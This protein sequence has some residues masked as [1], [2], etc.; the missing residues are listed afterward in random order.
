VRIAIIAPLVTTIREP[1]L[2]GSQSFVADLA[3]GL[4]VRRHE[5]HVYAATGSEIP[6]ATVIDTG[7]DSAALRDSLYRAAS[8]RESVGRPVE[9]AFARVYA[10]VRRLSYDLVHN[11]AFDAPAIT[12]AAVLEVPVVHTLHLP[13]ER[14]VASALQAARH[15]GR[16]P[17]VAAVS[18]SQADAWRA[19]TPVDA[20]LPNGVPTARVPWSASVGSGAVFAGRFS[21]EKGAAEAIDIA[22]AAGMRVDLYGA[23]Y[24]PAYTEQR[25][26]DRRGA[27]GVTVHPAVERK[28][29]WEIMAR[30]SV[31]LCPARWEEP[32]GLVAAEAQAT[33]TPVV[34]FRRGGLQEVVVD[35]VTGFLVVPDDI[36]A[37]AEAVGKASGLSRAACRRHAET[38]LDLEACLDLHENLYRE[39]TRSMKAT[40]RA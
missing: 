4:T 23:P 40:T 29:L 20:V 18:S 38:H 3:A 34:A 10:A 36:R 19:L 21:W 16:R 8:P 7:I 2:G 37:A 30:A 27:P 25:I 35:G 11:H 32:F 13:P 9:D 12:L 15:A 28:V 24:D 1:Q 17:T 6:G 26:H 5:I 33:G 31:V 39:V 14:L 22:M